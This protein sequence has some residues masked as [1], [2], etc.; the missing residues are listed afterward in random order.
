[1]LVNALRAAINALQAWK[2]PSD[3][4]ALR[5]TEMFTSNTPSQA[6]SALPQS[7]SK[8]LPESYFLRY[9]LITLPQI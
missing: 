4:D 8:K 7:G 9:F 5:A 6:S 1:M 2:R 3:A